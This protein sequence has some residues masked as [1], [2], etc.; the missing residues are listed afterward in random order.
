MDEGIPKRERPHH[1]TIL[2][3]IDI[4]E[5]NKSG[6]L[7]SKPMR[8]DQLRKYGIGARGQFFVSGPTEG[9]CIKEVK[10]IMEGMNG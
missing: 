4:R 1:A 6:E 10:K 2:F 8:D 9:A 3:Q 7:I 5:M